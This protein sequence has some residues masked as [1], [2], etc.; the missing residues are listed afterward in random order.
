[1]MRQQASR[2]PLRLPVERYVST[3]SKV[4]K[5]PDTATLRDVL[6]KF[7]EGHGAVVIVD[8][9]EKPLG[10]FTPSDVPRI[11]AAFRQ[12]PYQPARELMS[13]PVYAVDL[14]EPLEDALIKMKDYITGI[15]VIDKRTGKYAG[16]LYRSEVAQT[17]DVIQSNITRNV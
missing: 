5:L 1:M 12:K 13:T 6:V 8:A 4:N 16:Y 9:D 17:L 15:A 3:F 14:A 10:I 2:D 7:K 11:S